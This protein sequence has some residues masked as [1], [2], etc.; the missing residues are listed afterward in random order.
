MARSFF[1]F[2][3][4]Q[5]SPSL[6]GTSFCVFKHILQCFYLFSVL[7]NWCT[8]S[9]MLKWW[10]HNKGPW[11]GVW[12]LG[13][14]LKFCAF[15][16]WDCQCWAEVKCQVSGYQIWVSLSGDINFGLN[17]SVGWKKWFSV[18]CRKYP[19]HGPYNMS[20]KTL[21]QQSDFFAPL[22]L[23]GYIVI[24]KNNFYNSDENLSANMTLP[25]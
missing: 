15:W 9:S 14:D 4:P 16:E 1:D 13:V 18:G 7:N 5:Q 22:T 23:W 8:L 21:S 11:R 3:V 17:V 6:K 12:V 20:A 10:F 19:L 24:S 25:T 2:V